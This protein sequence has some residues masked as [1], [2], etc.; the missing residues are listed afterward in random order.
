MTCVPGLETLKD[1]QERH[2]AKILS[3]LLGM[4]AIPRD[5]PGVDDVHD[6][7]MVAA[8]GTRFAAEVVSDTSEAAR[9]FW[10]QIEHPAADTPPLGDG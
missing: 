7:D 4:E 5:V 2:A 6:F 1:P 3:V 8:D 10:D 9:F